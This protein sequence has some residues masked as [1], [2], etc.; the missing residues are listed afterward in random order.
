MYSMMD[1]HP[2]TLMIV[3]SAIMV[4]PFFAL[5]TYAFSAASL[6]TGTSIGCAFLV[7][8]GFMAWVCLAGIPASLGPA[9]AL[10]VPVCWMTPTIILFCFHSWFLEKPLS[11]HLLISLQ[12]W[13]VIGAVF[14][15]EMTQ[16]NIP[17]IFAYPAGI[18]DIAVAAIAALVLLKFR[19][20]KTIPRRAVMLVLVCGVADFMSAFFFGF[21]SSVGPQQ[22]FFPEIVNDSMQFPTGMIPLFLVPYAIFFHAL[23]WLNL[24]RH[25]A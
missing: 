7:W 14:L 21:T 8:G 22:I 16:G 12:L 4:T 1:A 25:G 3:M 11:Q 20:S 17:G 15:L 13:R 6:K 5:A 19:K 10:I 9:G 2:I 23:S 18:G 24:R